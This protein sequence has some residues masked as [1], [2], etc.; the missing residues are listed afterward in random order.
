MRIRISQGIIILVAI[1]WM[2]N[3]HSQFLNSQN[4]IPATPDV[5]ALAKNIDIPMNLSSGVPSVSIPIATVESGIAK[6]PVSLSYNASGIKVEETPTWVGLGFNLN[7]GGTITRVVRGLPDDNGYGYINSASNRKVS[8]V[9]ALPY[10]SAERNLIEL[11]LLPNQ[12]IDLEPDI[13][14]FSIMGYSGQFYWDQDSSRFILSPYQNVKFEITGTLGTFKITLPNGIGCYFGESESSIEQI[15]WSGTTSRVNG[16]SNLNT[17]EDDN[18]PY[19]TCWHINRIVTPTG[20]QIEFEYTREQITEYGRGGETDNLTDKTAVFFKRTVLQPVLTTITGENCEVNFIR[21]EDARLDV[22]ELDP[23]KSLESVVIENKNGMEIRNFQF[24]YDYFESTTTPLA[25]GI[26]IPYEAFA[27]KRLYLQSVKEGKGDQYQPAY[28]F[29]YNTPSLPDR[30][31]P[32]QDYWGYYNG[33][34]NPTVGILAMMPERLLISGLGIPGWPFELPS[35]TID[36]ADRRVDIDFAKAASL[37][38]I[39]YPTGGTT[40]FFYELND[41]QQLYYN[42]EAGFLPSDYVEKL[43]TFMPLIPA[44]PPYPL[45]YWD[46]FRIVKP[47][48]KVKITP[49]L[50]SPCSEVSSQ[51]CRYTITIKGLTDPNFS[52]IIINTTPVHYAILP[53][54]LYRIEAAVT[55]SAYDMPN[56]TVNLKWGAHPDTLNMKVGGL[57]IRQMVIN[58]GMGNA[59]TKNYQYTFPNSGYSS[60]VL[61]GCPTNIMIKTDTLGSYLGIDKIISNGFLP[62]TTDGQTIRYQFV[63]ETTS[64]GTTDLKTVY[65]FNHDFSYTI[66]GKLT[67]GEPQPLRSWQ[68]NLLTRKEIY[69]D[70]GTG[71]T[72]ISEEENSNQFDSPLQKTIG[73][74]GIRLVPY[75]IASEWYYPVSKTTT[76]YGPDGITNLKID[77]HYYYNDSHLLGKKVITNS[78][79]MISHEKIWYPGDYNNNATFNIDNL[80]NGYMISLPVKTETSVN[81]R[82]SNG[83]ITKYNQYGQPVEY[84]KYEGPV[85]ADTV[86][87]DRNIIQESG[88]VSKQTITYEG[89]NPVNI[90]EPGSRNSGF[91]W[92]YAGM[93]PVA[94]IQN[95]SDAQVAYT[96]FERSDSKG[97]WTYS[98]GT[99][100]VHGAVTGRTAYNLSGGAV[101]AGGMSTSVVYI[102]SYWSKGNVAISSGSQSNSVTGRSIGDWTYHEV[103]VTGTESV[104]ISGNTYIDELRLYPA[105]ARMTTYTYEPLIGMTSRCDDNNKI[106]YYEYDG[107][108]RLT[109]IRDEDN[110]ILKR[111]CYNYAGQPEPCIAPTLYENEKRSQ[112]FIRNN[113]ATGETGSMVTYTVPACTYHSTIDV[114]DAN[115]MAQDDINANGQDYAN[116]NGSCTVPSCPAPARR[117]ING[118]CTRGLM[119]YTSSV[120]EPNTGKYVCTY[121]Y[122]FPDGYQSPE[123]LEQSDTSC[124]IF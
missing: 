98:S 92:G 33:K 93:Y 97:H 87:H 21:S 15:N 117:M 84:F 81:G 89:E 85:A 103:H 40:E 100:T 52:D 46:T 24:T 111:I 86:V 30:L 75:S 120:Y 22:P 73:L 28:E 31:S 118:V 108:G 72:L 106:T 88:Y 82:I 76:E 77:Q 44:N 122:E 63:T 43:Y 36:G 95:A 107:L 17:V 57:R 70:D 50:P 49:N 90:T 68:N 104:T 16:Q 51:S 5:A 96:S 65:W 74:H 2:N 124:G 19:K 13:F 64:S 67:K 34:G 94:A 29:T 26:A 121:H 69:R 71:Q 54:G 113:C 11:Q 114:A 105:D 7:A 12:Q 53:T 6:L 99:T 59:V 45:S 1:C 56:F 79:G 4:V 55:G 58:D 38:S 42:P 23:R 25:W 10:N 109:L 47:L 80:R 83:I 37:K 112:T 60:G 66:L 9:K 20:K 18:V 116:Q 35:T 48:T 39:K 123:F 32:D 101:S 115:A 14:N 27:G 78:D 61:A 8:Y 119:V 3:V 62:L 110:K 91:I 41:V 102:I